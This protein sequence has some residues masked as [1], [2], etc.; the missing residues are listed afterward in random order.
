MTRV[1][2]SVRERTFC[3]RYVSLLTYIYW[4]NITPTTWLLNITLL[5][6]KTATN[7]LLVYAEL[8]TFPLYIHRHIRIIKYWLNLYN[9]KSGIK[10]RIH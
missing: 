2:Y 9:K 10:D 5:G 8:G 3:A 6:V 4:V 7:N 1:I